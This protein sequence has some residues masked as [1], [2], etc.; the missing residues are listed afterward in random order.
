MGWG[1]L[2][3]DMR[4]GG[5]WREMSEWVCMHSAQLMTMA[6]ASTATTTAPVTVPCELSLD[7]CN[8]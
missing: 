5:G 2:G 1:G 3:W 4:G 8:C 6:T 7:S